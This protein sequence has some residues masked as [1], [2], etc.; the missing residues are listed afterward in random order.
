VLLP[1]LAAA[2]LL[3]VERHGIGAQ[4]WVASAAMAGLL[5]APRWR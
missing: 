4:R 5:L 3:L 1:L 2:L